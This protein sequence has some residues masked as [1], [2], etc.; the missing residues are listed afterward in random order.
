MEEIPLSSDDDVRP[1]RS[2]YVKPDRTHTGRFA[3]INL[4]QKNKNGIYIYIIIM[5][6]YL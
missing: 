5:Y 1:Q 4:R 2:D 3:R 6:I